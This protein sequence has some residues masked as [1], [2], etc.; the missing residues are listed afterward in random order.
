MILYC[1][2]DDVYRRGEKVRELTASY[3]AKNP[4]GALSVV[5][6]DEAA[7]RVGDAVEFLRQPAL[8]AGKKLLSARGGAHVSDQE[9][10]RALKAF[11]D[12]EQVFILISDAGKPVKQLSFLAKPPVRRFEFG[13]LE[14]M[15]L[16]AFI[17]SV[18][19]ERG[20]T[21]STDALLFLC[22]Y[23]ESQAERSFSAVREIEKASFLPQ[24]VPK[25]ALAELTHWRKEGTFFDDTLALVKAQ[26]VGERLVLLEQLFSRR[27]DNE[28]VFNMLATLARG[29]G[30]QKLA[31]YDV[32]RKSGA[33]EV[34]EA[35]LGFALS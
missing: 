23:V 4:D 1:F 3:R 35:L 26:Q 18:A 10:V 13:K 24:P 22:A 20:V 34:E 30:A 11:L 31:A 14:G 9:W 33:L 15:E 8:F 5:D 19:A 25:G 12:D 17:R 21:F 16:G 29:E 28:Y 2:G 27:E 6:F 32:C 7:E